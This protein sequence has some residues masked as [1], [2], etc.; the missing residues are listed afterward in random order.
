LAVAMPFLG[1]R[2]ETK[3]GTFRQLTLLESITLRKPIFQK[4]EQMIFTAKH[5]S[6]T[7]LLD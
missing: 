3:M 2:T 5:L 6:S 7:R 4:P 1:F